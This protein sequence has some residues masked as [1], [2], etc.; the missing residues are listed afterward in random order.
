MIP[1]SY[2][3]SQ[4]NVLQYLTAVR[5]SEVSARRDV[6]CCYGHLAVTDTPWKAVRY[7][8][9]INYRCLNEINSRYYKHSLLRT[10]TP[11][12]EGV[13]NKGS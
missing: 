8:A 2:L 13:S 11:G 7:P 1:G 12:P 3:L 4:A 10:L 9:K 6:D 5:N